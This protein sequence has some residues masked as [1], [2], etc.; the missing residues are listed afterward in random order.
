MAIHEERVCKG[1]K[2]NTKLELDIYP[3]RT[4]KGIEA[5]VLLHVTHG[6]AFW[7][8]QGRKITFFLN[9]N[10]ISEQITDKDGRCRIT[11]PN[12]PSESAKVVLLVHAEETAWTTPCKISV[13]IWQKTDERGDTIVYTERVPTPEEKEKAPWWEKALIGS[14]VVIGLGVGGYLLIR[15][16]EYRKE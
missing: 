5:N 4:R 14:A 7:N 10:I 9:G 13:D 1:L 2:E 12:I 8:D 15:G 11:I 3:Y 6:P 16:V